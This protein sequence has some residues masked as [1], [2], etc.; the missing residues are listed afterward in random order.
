MRDDVIARQRAAM[1]EAGLDALV[2]ISPENFAY[3][4]G[5]VVPSQPLMRWRHAIAVVP[6]D[7]EVGLVSVDMEETTVR[8]K[9]DGVDIRVWGEFSDDPMESLAALLNDRGLGDK[10]IGIEMDYLPAGGSCAAD[11]PNARRSVRRG[12]GAVGAAAPDQDPGRDGAA[13]APVAYRR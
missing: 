2:A 12:G 10:T 5:F 6:A 7:G 11:R 9:A 1:G 8:G 4:T 3:T 13:E